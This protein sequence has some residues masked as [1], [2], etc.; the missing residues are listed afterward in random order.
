MR[1]NIRPKPVMLDEARSTK[2]TKSKTRDPTARSRPS[3][4]HTHNSTPKNFR[5][6]N[7]M[8]SMEMNH[9]ESNASKTGR[10]VQ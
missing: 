10:I 7:D 5:N 9:G 6:C 2:S 1:N 8:A 4:Y 3:F